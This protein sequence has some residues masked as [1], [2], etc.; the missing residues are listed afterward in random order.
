MDKIVYPSYNCMCKV[1]PTTLK[2]YV[3]NNSSGHEGF[4]TTFLEFSKSR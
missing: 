2:K 4:V 3:I 1:M